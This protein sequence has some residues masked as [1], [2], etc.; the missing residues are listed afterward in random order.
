MQIVGMLSRSV[1]TWILLAFVIATPLTIW[2]VNG[3]LE[4]FAY[5]ISMGPLAFVLAGGITLL[6]AMLTMSFHAWQATRINPVEALR[7]E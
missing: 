7:D 1:I 5:R 4:T 2:L 3:W 6:V